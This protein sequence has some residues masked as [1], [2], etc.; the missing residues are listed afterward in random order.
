MKVSIERHD[1]INLHQDFKVVKNIVKT[2]MY[3]WWNNRRKESAY[4]KKYTVMNVFFYIYNNFS[5]VI[6]SDAT[7]TTFFSL[8]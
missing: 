3:V 7:L 6:S 5:R 4:E 8:V 1:C 2:E